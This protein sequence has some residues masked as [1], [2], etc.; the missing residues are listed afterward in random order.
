MGSTSI[1]PGVSELLQTL[2]SLNS[3]ALSSPAVVSALEKAPPSDIVQLSAAAAE[4]AGVDA[5]F[6]VSD[7]AGGSDGTN[8]LMSALAS[9]EGGGGAVSEP[10]GTLFDFT[11]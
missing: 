10:T 4:L 1:N 8:S 11:G 2:S 3:P 9:V 6:G 7:G 5:M